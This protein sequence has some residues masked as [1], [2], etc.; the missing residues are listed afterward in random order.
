MVDVERCLADAGC[1]IPFPV[2]AYADPERD[3][4]LMFR[5]FEYMDNL[6]T[7]GQKVMKDWN[8]SASALQHAG[9]EGELVGTILP[10][11]LFSDCQSLT[12]NL[13]KVVPPKEKNLTLSVEELKFFI[14]QGNVA[15]HVRS[16]DQL[17]DPLTK[18]FSYEKSANLLG[19]L[20]EDSEVRGLF[21]QN[22]LRRKYTGSAATAW[23]S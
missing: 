16:E 15:K 12:S 2:P 1:D 21:N 7:V 6:V 14:L 17:A 23:T 4:K 9:T 13:V 19:R 18:E 20:V 11:T 22:T 3:I 10:I 8:K 5:Q